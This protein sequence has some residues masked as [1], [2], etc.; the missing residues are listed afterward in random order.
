MK[1][2]SE[3]EGR[4]RGDDYAQDMESIWLLFIPLLKNAA[5]FD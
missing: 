5:S 1:K 3:W 4:G 2:L